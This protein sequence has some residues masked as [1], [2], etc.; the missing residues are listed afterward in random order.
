MPKLAECVDCIAEGITTWRPVTGVR[1][2]RCATHVRAKKKADKQRSRDNRRRNTYGLTEEDHRELLARQGGLCAICGPVT[3]N[4]GARRDLSTDHD[5]KCCN[6]P[7]SC[8]RCVR[9]LLC[10]TC[11]TILGR[12]RDNPLVPL[13]MI[14][15][16]DNP[17]WQQILK[18]RDHE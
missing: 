13:R 14:Q 9:G 17:P 10:S 2:K 8:G 16:L 6:G 7:T 1:V 3:G 15:Y 5:H 18:E 4:R 12:W 11:N